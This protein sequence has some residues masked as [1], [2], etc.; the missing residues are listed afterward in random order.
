MIPQVLLQALADG[1]FHSGSELGE[2][3]GVSRTAVWKSLQKLE[4]LGLVVDTVKGKGYRLNRA[5]DLLDASRILSALP[6]AAQSMLALRVLQSTGSTNSD[7]SAW[8]A[9][10]RRCVYCVVL[11]EQQTAGR[12]RHGRVWVSPF[13][14]NLYLSLAYELKGGVEALSGLSLVVGIALIRTLKTLGVEDAALK[15]PNDVWLQ[16]RKLAGVLVEL[17]GEATSGWRVVIGIGLNVH[18]RAEDGQQIDQPWISLDAAKVVSR[19][20]L[21]ALLIE[22]LVEVLHEFS[23]KGFAAF[24]AEWS[25][26]DALAG[27]RVQIDG[28]RVVGEARGIDVTGAFL[29]QPDQGALIVINAG[30][31]SVRPHVA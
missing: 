9:E 7:A 5:L 25:A 17:Q 31:V 26:A 19:N 27:R 1:E 20:D 21:A 8:L 11:A 3:L 24:V 28:G 18:M 22:T 29:L 15:W 30:E 14:Q 4:A 16:G 10:S 13:A 2:L 12:G 6:E 23:Q